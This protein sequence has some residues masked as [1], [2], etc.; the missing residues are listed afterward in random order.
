[1]G[2]R[3]FLFV[4]LLVGA[5]SALLS[6]YQLG[7][8]RAEE[9][10]PA[11]PAAAYDDEP[12][13][14]FSLRP[15]GHGAIAWSDLLDAPQAGSKVDT[16]ASIRGVTDWATN[17]NGPAVHEA[18]K[19]LSNQRMLIAEIGEAAFVFGLTGLDLAGLPPEERP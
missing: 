17:Q 6:V 13:D 11:A 9:M 2:S 7:R 4:V 10:P 16:K 1:M 12:I 14:H 3:R 18:W 19:E 15:T 5:M 8:S